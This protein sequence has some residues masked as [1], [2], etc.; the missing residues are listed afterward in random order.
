MP[1]SAIPD[2]FSSCGHR[3]EYDPPAIYLRVKLRIN[4]PMARN[5]PGP[6][7]D[8][9]RIVNYFRIQC[10]VHSS[11]AQVCASLLGLFKIEGP[12]IGNHPVVCFVASINTSTHVRPVSSFGTKEFFLYL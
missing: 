5:Q 3:Y 8:V 11:L 12:L 2:Y 7:A 10:G 1:F 4:Q 6:W 9:L